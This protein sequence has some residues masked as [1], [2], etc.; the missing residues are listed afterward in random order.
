MGLGPAHYHDLVSSET[1]YQE[2]KRF[3]NEWNRRRTQW[4]VA[5]SGSESSLPVPSSPIWGELTQGRAEPRGQ[6]ARTLPRF[7]PY[8]RKVGGAMGVGGLYHSITIRNA[9]NDE[10]IR[11][12]RKT[13]SACGRSASYCIGP[14]WNIAPT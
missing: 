13:S 9:L 5:A 6:T 14:N 12:G 7:G 8:N 1:N 10:F 4:E 3:A 2:L 11:D